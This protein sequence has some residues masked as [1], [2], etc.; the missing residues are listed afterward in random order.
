MKTDSP[1]IGV[2][3]LDGNDLCFGCC[4][5]VDEI[6]RWPQM[7]EYEKFCLAVALDERRQV[8]RK[9]QTTDEHR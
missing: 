8:I 3:K 7:T 1:C 9:E 5:T 2:C 4:R 6:A